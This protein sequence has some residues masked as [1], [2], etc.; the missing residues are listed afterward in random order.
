MGRLNMTKGMPG[1]RTWLSG[2]YVRLSGMGLCGSGT[3]HG[4]SGAGSGATLVH[5]SLL[6]RNS[7][8]HPESVSKVS[9]SPRAQKCA[10]KARDFSWNGASRRF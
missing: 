10:P 8:L 1:G 5:P 4:G 2:R 6:N 9:I 3:N 7:F